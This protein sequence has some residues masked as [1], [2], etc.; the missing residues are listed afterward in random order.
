MEHM[1]LNIKPQFLYDDK[2]N[3]KSVLLSRRDYQKIEA[4]IEDYE[5][6]I[7]LLRAERE[8]T[9]FTIYEEFRMKWLT[10]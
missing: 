9:S 5:D 6:T 7:D 10:A 3:P 8:A 4:M 1:Q 2:G